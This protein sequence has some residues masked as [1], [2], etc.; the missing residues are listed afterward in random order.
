MRSEAE[1]RA[2]R[3]KWETTLGEGSDDGWEA[4]IAALNWVLGDQA[5]LSEYE[6]I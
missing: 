3:S 6:P 5:D 2:E 4:I 1:I